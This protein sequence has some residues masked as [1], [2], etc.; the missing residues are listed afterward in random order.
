MAFFEKSHESLSSWGLRFQTATDPF[1]IYAWVAPICSKSQNETFFDQKIKLCGKASPFFLS[2]IYIAASK[3]IILRPVWIWALKRS[4]YPN[5]TFERKSRFLIIYGLRR[6]KP[7]PPHTMFCANI[8]LSL[9][10]K[11]KFDDSYALLVVSKETEPLNS[12]SIKLLRT[13]VKLKCQKSHFLRTRMSA[14]FVCQSKP[15]LFA[16]GHRLRKGCRPL[17]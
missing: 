15:C 8:Y 7:P 13:A 11:N 2:I 1:K 14:K 3:L 5:S 12:H 17:S 16:F 4:H 10:I 9:Y 6:R